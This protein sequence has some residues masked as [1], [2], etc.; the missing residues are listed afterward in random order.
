MS[1]LVQNIRSMADMVEA[2]VL[3]EYPKA[4]AAKVE[5][6]VKDAYAEYLVAK[7]IHINGLKGKV[8]G[9][10]NGRILA[11]QEPLALTV[12][13]LGLVNVEHRIRTVAGATFG[14]STSA[15]IA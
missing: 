2:I 8:E 11:M 9:L 7:V 13:L 6:I 4:P 5:Q 12:G 1:D 15:K 14:K 3:T 10:D